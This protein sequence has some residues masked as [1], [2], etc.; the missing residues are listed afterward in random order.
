[1]A[2][3][4]NQNP[5]QGINAHLNSELQTPG[6]EDTG[7]STW[8]GFL[9]THVTHIADFLNEQLPPNYVARSEQSLQIGVQEDVLLP[10][11]TSKQEP[12]V[13]IYQRSN[14]SARSSRAATSETAASFDL[15]LDDTLDLTE[16]FVK[17]VVIRQVSES[18]HI[19]IVVTR[20][21]LLSPTN[22]PGHAGYNAYRRNRNMALYSHVPLL[23]YP[24]YP[25]DP[26]SR[27]YNILVSDPRPSV[28]EGRLRAYGFRVDQPFHWS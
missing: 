21:E 10:E 26:K 19:G 14:T 7:L 15:A 17:A 1:M 5:Y 6:S 16:D 11:T 13:A 9:S 24:V 8:P 22:K 18:D 3:D 2:F 28:K 4:P 27:P 25:N 23:N 20:I 12:D